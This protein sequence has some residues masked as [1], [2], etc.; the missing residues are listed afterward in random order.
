MPHKDLQVRREYKRAFS[1][2][3]SQR[4]IQ[5]KTRESPGYR[6]R[7][8]PIKRSSMLRQRY[9]ITQDDYLRMLASQN[10]ACAVCHVK[11]PGNGR[12]ERYFDVDHNHSS[13]QVRGLLCRNC[14]TTLGTIENK[15]ALISKLEIYLRKHSKVV[16]PI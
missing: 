6:D 16:K 13:G 5:R 1:R 2:L 7:M 14:N 10:N 11:T 8:D 3:P 15:R 9:G 12:G 4:A